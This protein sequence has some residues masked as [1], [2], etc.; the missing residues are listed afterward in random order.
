MGWDRFTNWYDVNR[1][2]LLIGVAVGAAIVAAM[3]LLRS[4]GER[5]IRRDPHGMSWRTVIGRVLAKTSLAFMILAAADVVST[6]AELPHK[7]GRLID[8]ASSSPSRCRGR[9]G[10]AK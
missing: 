2:G 1:D 8:I 6:Y 9:C 7:V 10:A 4:L 5:A 3:L